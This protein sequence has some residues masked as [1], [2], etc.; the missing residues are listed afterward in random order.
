MWFFHGDSDSVVSYSNSTGWVSALNGGTPIVPAA[1]LTTL[2]GADHNI[3]NT[4]YDYGYNIGN[5]QNVYQWLLSQSRGAATLLHELLFKNGSTLYKLLLYSD[6]T[7]TQ[8]QFISG[9]WT[10][11]TKQ[12]FNIRWKVGSTLY[13][14][15]M[16][17]TN[18]SFL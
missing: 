5:G 12:N 13:R 15:A 1:Q 9:S 18:Y 4:V 8:Q 3:W 17:S 7:W 10:D 2:V 14:A 11:V 16:T 6:N